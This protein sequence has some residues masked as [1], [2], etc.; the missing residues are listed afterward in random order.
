M[1]INLLTVK[2]KNADMVDE[3]FGGSSTEVASC[4]TG[5]ADPQNRPATSELRADFER[6]A[7]RSRNFC[8]P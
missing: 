7:T 1:T 6:P 8:G 5:V 3:P 2:D 4:E